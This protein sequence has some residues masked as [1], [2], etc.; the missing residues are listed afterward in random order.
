MKRSSALLTIVALG[1]AGCGTST[2][3]A[4]EP[5]PPAATTSSEEETD[6]EVAETSEEPAATTE[7]P[8]EE[9][10]P[11]ETT[12]PD[13]EQAEEAEAETAD[14][15]FGE[16]VVNDRGNLVK[17]V[18]QLAGIGDPDGEM[19]VEFT[20]TDLEVGF[21]CTS[22]WADEPANGQFIAMTFEVE[23]FPALSESSYFD[24]FY[25][26]E[27]DFTLFSEEGQR[28]ND[29]TGNAYMCLDEG[30]RLPS[31]MGPGEK[32]TGVLV[33]DTA[34]DSGSIVYSTYT[35]DGEGAWE[36]SF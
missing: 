26:S 34:L 17:E 15:R 23:T 14:D 32:A 5:A 28:E 24:S 8:T 9:A 33:L 4:T 18:G 36:W 21:E 13:D 2:P 12:A 30:D 11:E 3:T 7:E 25:M 1:L 29:S 19:A 27:Y 6:P 35:D 31:D 22:E 10:Q 20:M 16:S